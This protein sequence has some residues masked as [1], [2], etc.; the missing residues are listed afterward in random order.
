MNKRIGDEK[1]LT[2]I[3]VLAVIVISSIMLIFASSLIVQAMKNQE[4]ITSEA[5]LRD[6]ADIMM[7]KLMKDIFTLKESEIAKVECGTMTNTLVTTVSCITETDNLSVDDLAKVTAA[8]QA[9]TTCSQQIGCS[10]Y[11]LVY[12]KNNKKI[13]FQGDTIFTKVEQ[14][15]LANKNIKLLPYYTLEIKQIPYEKS[16]KIGKSTSI[17]VAFQLSNEM[18]TIAESFCNEIMIVDDQ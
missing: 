13:G 5:Q 10:Q 16:E 17:I 7:A 4:R 14:Y 15:T 3:E 1:G 12:L 8:K 18:K 11:A 6:E 9:M 2:L